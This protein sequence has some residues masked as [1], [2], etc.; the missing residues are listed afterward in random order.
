MTTAYELLTVKQLDKKLGVLRPYFNLIPNRGWIFYIRNALSISTGNLAK[1]MGLKQP[2]VVAM[3]Q[4]EADKSITLETLEKAANAVGC[5]VFYAFVPKDSFEKFVDSKRRELVNR[6]IT[7]T[8]LTMSL[9]E[10]GLSKKE[11]AEQTNLLMDDM[12]IKPLKKLWRDL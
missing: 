7:E 2:S 9:E 4:R 5:D 12:R 1:L 10:Q 11:I 3:E 8:N 6:I